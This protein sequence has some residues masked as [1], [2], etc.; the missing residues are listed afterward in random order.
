MNLGYIYLTF[1][2]TGTNTNIE[3]HYLSF[4]EFI[5]FEPQVIYQVLQKIR[6]KTN[7]INERKIR[8]GT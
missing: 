6:K 5:H 1:L 8:M 4:F 2:H 3:R 7:D